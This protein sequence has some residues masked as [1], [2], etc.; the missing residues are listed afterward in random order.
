MIK[1]AGAAAPSKYLHQ[2]LAFTV[3]EKL[4]QQWKSIALNAKYDKTNLSQPRHI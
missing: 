3:P 1:Y 4:T 2:P